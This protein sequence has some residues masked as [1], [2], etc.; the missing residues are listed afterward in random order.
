MLIQILFG[1]LL[2]VFTTLIAAGLAGLALIASQRFRR[3][4]L[5]GHL[6]LKTIMATVA[7]ALLV[8][9]VMTLVVWVW[10]IAF[11]VIGV[12][13][14]V[15]EALYFSIVAFTTLGFGDIILPDEWRLLSGFIAMDGFILF[16]LSTAFL[17][18]AF[19][20]LRTALN[21]ARKTT[22]VE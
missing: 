6:H 7:L 4:L 19:N 15:E 1:T 11:L 5:K 18:E 9:A 13:V 14:T 22:R 12:F 10:A 20:V 16:G 21:D 17:F 3:W 8:V 2:T